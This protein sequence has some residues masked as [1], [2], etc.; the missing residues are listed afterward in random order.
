MATAP[1]ALLIASG[2]LS[3]VGTL[4]Q[5]SSQA[6]AASYNAKVA[7][8]QA[9]Y[10]QQ[11]AAENER[12]QRIQSRQ[13]IGQLRANYGASGLA[14][15]SSPL[16][17]LEAS[18]MNAELDALTIRH[19]GAVQA[20]DYRNQSALYRSQARSSMIGGGLTAATKLGVTAYNAYSLLPD[21]PSITDQRNAQ[22]GPYYSG[23]PTLTLTGP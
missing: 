23:S 6:Q 16:D 7:Q 22:Y 11:A 10:A 21:S 17:I 13:Q 12:R 8:Q 9:T 5:A 19:Q 1:L 4:A 15:E 14:L 20:N 2:V 3:A 18:A